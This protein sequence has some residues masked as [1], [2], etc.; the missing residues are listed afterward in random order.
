MVSIHA[1][2]EGCDQ[3]AVE[4]GYSGSFV[5]IHA[6]WEGCDP[7]SRGGVAR[8]DHVSI[9]A[10]WEGCDDERIVEETLRIAFQFTHP[11]KGATLVC[12]ICSVMVLFQFTHPGK[13]ATYSPRRRSRT[14]KFQFTHP[15]K[16]ATFSTLFK[17][18][19]LMPF[20]FTH[21]G[22]GATARRWLSNCGY[23]VSIH[24]P[25]EGCDLSLLA[26]SSVTK[27]FNSRTLGRVRPCPALEYGCFCQF[28]F[29]HPGKGATVTSQ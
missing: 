6:P 20:Q 3:A 17:F 25:W 16:G 5:S 23:P 12:W 15:G 28:Q 2:W 19:R 22:K 7:V 9:H 10:P 29:T 21:P 18:Q 1:P 4:R 13:G 27:C 24:A 14:T 11:G 8:R 26:L